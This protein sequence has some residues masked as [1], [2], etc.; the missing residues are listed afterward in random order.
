MV[1]LFAGGFYSDDFGYVAKSCK[2]C[3]NGSF[4]PLEKTPGTRKQDCKSCP[5]GNKCLHLRSECNSSSYYIWVIDQ[6]LGQ[7]GWMLLLSIVIVLASPVFVHPQQEGNCDGKLRGEREGENRGI[8]GC[9]I[10]SSLT[11]KQ[12]DILTSLFPIILI[13]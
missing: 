5:E 1:V 2:K 9:L 6:V 4:V 12:P 11:G 13:T 3:P 7:R 8:A 10:S